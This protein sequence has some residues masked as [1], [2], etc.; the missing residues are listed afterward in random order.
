MVAITTGTRGGYTDH[1]FLAAIEDREGLATMGNPL[2]MDYMI[3]N[4]NTIFGPDVASLKG[5]TTSKTYNPV[6]TEYV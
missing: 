4:F 6:V 3:W 1:E 5:K 2:P